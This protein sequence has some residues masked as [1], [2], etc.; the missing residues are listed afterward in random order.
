MARKGRAGSPAIGR[1]LKFD[2]VQA[3]AAVN[4]V[5]RVQTRCRNG[6][7]EIPGRAIVSWPPWPAW[8]WPCAR[9]AESSCPSG[10]RFRRRS[11]SS[12]PLIRA[13]SASRCSRFCNFFRASS[14]KAMTS[15][16][17]APYL[18]LSDCSRLNRSSNCRRR[19]GSTSIVVG[20]TAQGGLQFAP[21][22]RRPARGIE[23]SR[24]AAA[25]QAL[26][27][28]QSAAQ[29]AGLAQ[30][31]NRPARPTNSAPPG[32]IPAGARRCRRAEIPAPHAPPRPAAIGRRKSR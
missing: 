27:G 25:I 8:E 5:G 30:Q 13:S 7:V 9:C 18:R 1:E 23:Q 14:P 3:G 24:C 20:V 15:A 10:R 22:R 2:F 32:S 4:A 11:F 16:S 19:P 26:Q 28:L 21:A 12:S 6:S 17:V 31:A 29:C